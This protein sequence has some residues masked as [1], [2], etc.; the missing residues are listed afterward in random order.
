MNADQLRRA[1]EAAWAAPEAVDD[2][3]DELDAE[4][5]RTKSIV[6]ATAAAPGCSRDFDRIIAATEAHCRAKAEAEIMAWLRAGANDPPTYGQRLCASI[7]DAIERG[8][9]RNKP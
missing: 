1:R 8:E 7:A 6:A 5:Q 9:H 3:L 4:I 2:A